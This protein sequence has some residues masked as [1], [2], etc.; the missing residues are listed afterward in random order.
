MY[1]GNNNARFIK[2]KNFIIVFIKSIYIIIRS[3]IVPV[4]ILYLEKKILKILI[5]L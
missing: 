4:Y 3:K 5:I 2:F 1:L